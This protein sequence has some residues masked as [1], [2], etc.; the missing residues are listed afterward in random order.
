MP[1]V[2]V[3]IVQGHLQ[4]QQWTM[5]QGSLPTELGRLKLARQL[6]GSEKKKMKILW[7]IPQILK[8]KMKSKMK[9][10]LRPKN[11]KSLMKI[12]DMKLKMTRTS[13]L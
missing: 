11:Q 1:A 6:R 8:L 5:L 12:Q 13:K 7:M 10:R 4:V 3:T 9:P 2:H